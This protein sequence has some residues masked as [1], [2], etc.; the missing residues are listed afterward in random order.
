MA[1]AAPDETLLVLGRKLGT[2]RHV[3]GATLRTVA[4]GT[5][6]TVGFL[7]QLERGQTNVS[8][9][10]LKRLS[11]FFGVSLRELFDDGSSDVHVSRA[12]E[13]RRLVWSDEGVVLESLTPPG[14]R[15]LGVVLVQAAPGASDEASY[16]HSA[17]ELT[18]VLEGEVLY[19]VDDEEYVLRPGD[20]IF[21]SRGARHE[22]RSLAV[23]GE[24]R[25]L[26]VSTPATL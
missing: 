8:V 16:P 21:H 3:R 4:A 14:S 1:V 11:D 7:S 17:D 19:R 12:G 23:D 10:N 24:T 26:T 15:S 22:W 18:V 5:G 20:A 25:L 9:A 6:L 13:R 2:L